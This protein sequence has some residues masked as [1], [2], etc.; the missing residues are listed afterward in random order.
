MLPASKM[1]MR[2]TADLTVQY[3]QPHVP[4]ADASKQ[5]TFEF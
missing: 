2:R 3:L 4:E 1:K 5:Y